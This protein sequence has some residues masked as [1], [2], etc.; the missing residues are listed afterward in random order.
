MGTHKFQNEID[1]I[2]NLEEKIKRK[3]LK[4][5]TSQYVYGF[6]QIETMRP[7]GDSIYTGK[8][9]IDKA[10]MDQTNV[11]ENMVKFDNKS[12]LKKKEGKDK[13][14][15]NFDSGSTLYHGW[16]LTI[17][18]FRS[19]TFPKQHQKKDVYKW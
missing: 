12:R 18:A 9:N 14:W 11:L 5:K 8:I 16:E 13:K 4:Y 6:Q 17:N 19:R 15:I 3:D 10:V 7:F 2:K 1:E